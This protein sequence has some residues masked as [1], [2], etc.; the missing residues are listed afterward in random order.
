MITINFFRKDIGYGWVGLFVTPWFLDFDLSIMVVSIMLV[1]IKFPIL[2]LSFWHPL[3]FKNVENALC[4]FHEMVG[5]DGPIREM[6]RSH[7]S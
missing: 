5:K 7:E 6:K 2:P 3:V 1:C 4:I